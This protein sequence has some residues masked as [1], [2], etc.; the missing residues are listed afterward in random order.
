MEVL[1]ILQRNPADSW[2]FR[3]VCSGGEADLGVVG[4]KVRGKA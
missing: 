2:K 4:G 3:F 1:A